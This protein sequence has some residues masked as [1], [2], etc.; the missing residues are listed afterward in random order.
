MF[1][2]CGLGIDADHNLAYI[3]PGQHRHQRLRGGIEA[4]PYLG[5]ALKLTSPSPAG[6]LIERAGSTTKPSLVNVH[7]RESPNGIATRCTLNPSPV[8]D[9]ED[10]QSTTHFPASPNACRLHREQLPHGLR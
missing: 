1:Q 5:D 10:N 7:D 3:L 8:T 9:T 6:Q 4:F 2:S